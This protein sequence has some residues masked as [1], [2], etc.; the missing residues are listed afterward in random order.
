MEGF[1]LQMMTKLEGSGS[2]K[3]GGLSVFWS[4][5]VAETDYFQSLLLIRATGPPPGLPLGQIK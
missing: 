1:T 3:E 2:G 5:V 4:Q